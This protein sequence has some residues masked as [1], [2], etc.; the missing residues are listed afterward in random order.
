M[1]RTFSRVGDRARCT[2]LAGAVLLAGCAG[3]PSD[4]PP[5]CSDRAR[6][7]LALDG[8]PVPE[9]CAAGTPDEAY[10]LG[11]MIRERRMTIERITERLAADPQPGERERIMLRQQLIRAQGELPE[12]EALARL[13]GWLPPAALPDR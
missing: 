7:E 6:F 12:L 3:S 11:D 13:E 9:A 10:G 1:N 2:A 8:A 5:D 4:P